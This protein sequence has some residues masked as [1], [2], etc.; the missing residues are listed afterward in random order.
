MQA[1]DRLRRADEFLKYLRDISLQNPNYDFNHN[2]IYH[3]LTRIGVPIDKRNTP[4]NYLFSNWVTRF[5]S[6]RNID[7]FVDPNWSYFCQFIT[8]REKVYSAPEHLKVYIPLDEEHMEIGV[9]MIFDFLSQNDIPNLSKVGKHQRFDSVVVRL[10]SPDDVEKLMAFINSNQYIQEGLYAPNPFT[11]NRSGI[12]MACD[13]RLS[14]NSAITDYIKMYIATRKRDNRLMDINIEDFY[15]FVQEY[16][17]TH[18]SSKEG[19]E[20]VIRDFDIKDNFD[21]NVVNYANVTELILK[22]SNTNFNF[23]DYVA[24]YNECANQSIQ[25]ARISKVHDLRVGMTLSLSPEEIEETNQLLMFA[26]ETMEN[27]YG[28]SAMHYNIAYYIQYGEPRRLTSDKGL[29]D[30]IVSSHFRENI[31]QLLR[32]YNTDIHSYI[33]M[34]RQRKIIDSDITEDLDVTDDLRAVLDAMIPKYGIDVT[35]EYLTSFVRTGSPTCITRDNGLR[36]KLGNQRFQNG[37]IRLIDTKNMSLHDIIVELAT[38]K[39]TTFGILDSALMA[40]FDKYEKA[41]NE[42]T[43]QVDGHYAARAALVKLFKT[44]SFDGFTRDKNCRTKLRENLSREAILAY[45]REA[46]HMPNNEGS[47]TDEEINYLSSQYADMV[48]SRE[49]QKQAKGTL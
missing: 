30:T 4:H 26:I 41:H 34:I 42:G 28:F 1:N 10:I 16:Y 37:L 46:L 38:K 33:D 45:V 14:Y 18:F 25:Q 17:N 8:H 40:N 23:Y 29:R 35:I 24:H 36:V 22:T 47:L 15:T 11:Y 44:G 31:T 48:I 27:K 20:A 43:S 32:Q 3:E 9:N 6:N 21:A 2:S 5:Q 12:A 7:V 39:D 13:G 19:I 49:M